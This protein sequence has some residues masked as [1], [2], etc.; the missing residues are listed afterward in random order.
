MKEAC[1]RKSTVFH[2]CKFKIPRKVLYAAYRFIYMRYKY[3]NTALRTAI[4]P[5]KGRGGAGGLAGC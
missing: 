3:E 4:A 2:F 5:G 1:H